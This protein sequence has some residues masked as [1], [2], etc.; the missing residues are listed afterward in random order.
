MEL[1]KA[2][3][4][5]A[6]IWAMYEGLD[7][8]EVEV[9]YPKTYELKS[10]ETRLKEVD[11]LTKLV[12]AVPSQTYR[13][14]IFKRTAHILFGNRVTTAT[15]ERIK[16][17]VDS[18]PAAVTTDSKTINEDVLSGILSAATGSTL[19]GYPDGEAEKAQEEHAKRQEL[20]AKAQSDP[21]SR[22]ATDNGDPLNAKI[23]K[24]DGSQKKGSDDPVSSDDSN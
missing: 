14:E 19:R 17:E 2:E 13:R 3:L 1:H 23:A 16:S 18:S 24:L 20:I 15:L 4:G 10:D 9:Y 11:S 5:I 12:T 6:Q 8:S 7:Y 22:G 21:A